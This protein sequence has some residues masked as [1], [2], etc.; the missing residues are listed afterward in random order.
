MSY[1]VYKILSY[2]L[3]PPLIALC[4]TLVFSLLSP[5]GLGSIDVFSSIAI[6]SVFLALIPIV[7]IFYF[8]KGDIEVK[9]KEDRTK[10]Y[11]VSIVCYV[12]SS[13]IFWVLNSHVMFLISISYVFVTSVV[14]VINLFW[15]I[16]VHTAGTA[17]PITAL[18]YAFG[19]KLV[20]LYALVLLVFW[21]RLKIKA[22]S[23]LQ[24]VTGAVVAIFITL[25][26]Y[27]IMW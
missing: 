12:T 13:A 15:K 1:D 26:V 10:L 7:F 18:V 14:A 27:T 2:L 6:G 22:H 16:S 19:I 23:F 25:T 20:P 24:L 8:Y 17:G 21:A 3:S 9:K 5:I 4:V 11:L